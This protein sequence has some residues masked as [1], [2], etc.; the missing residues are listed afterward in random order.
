MSTKVKGLLKGLRYISQ[1]F[2]KYRFHFPSM[3]SFGLHFPA[4]VLVPSYDIVFN[5]LLIVWLPRMV[6]KEW[7][8][9]ISTR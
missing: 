5:G 8:L 1:I 6:E 3:P 4:T 7:V 2:G 9:V